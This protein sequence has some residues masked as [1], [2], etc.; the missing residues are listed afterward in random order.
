MK[1]GLNVGR[2]KASPAFIERVNELTIPRH[3]RS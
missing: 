3:P 1:I 2:D